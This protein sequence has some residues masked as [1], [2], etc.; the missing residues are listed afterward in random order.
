[1]DY[2]RA[3]RAELKDPAAYPAWLTRHGDFIGKGLQKYARHPSI[4][5]KYEWLR[6]YH[7]ATI[8][9]TKERP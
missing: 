4:R 5:E 9:R 2:L 6:T 7:E 3:L 8:N 1:M